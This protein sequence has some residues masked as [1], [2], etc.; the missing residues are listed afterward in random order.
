MSLHEATEV[1]LNGLCQRCHERLL[2]GGHSFVKKGEVHVFAEHGVGRLMPLRLGQNGEVHL[3]E[4]L[5][6]LENASGIS[7]Q[8]RPQRQTAPRAAAILCFSSADL[9]NRNPTLPPLRRMAHARHPQPSQSMRRN[10]STTSE[11]RCAPC[12]ANRGGIG[13]NKRMSSPADAFRQF[14]QTTPPNVPVEIAGLLEA[15]ASGPPPPINSRA[16]QAF[17]YELDLPVIELHCETCQRKQNFENDPDTKSFN[18]IANFF[19]YFTCKNCGKGQKVIALRAAQKSP[20]AGQAI[21]V[22]LV[23]IGEFPTFGPP[24]SRRVNQLLD[25]AHRELFRKGLRA[26]AQGLGIA[27]SAY[28]RRIVEEQ[29]SRVLAEL[30]KVAVQLGE[31]DLT[32]YDQAA[33][34]KRFTYAIDLVSDRLPP[35]LRL[36]DGSNPLKLLHKV[37]SLDVHTRSDEDCLADGTAV[38]NVL[39][40]LLERVAEVT[41]DHTA[42]K[43][44]IERIKAI[45]AGN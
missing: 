41:R 44:S 31:T 32:V 9:K 4:G 22:R 43:Q 13:D 19:V 10:R 21:D 18:G 45:N 33:G 24:V 5:G 37:L 2:D 39:S 3:P 34:E 27:A 11:V 6:C 17:T 1:G 38:K 15:R 30:R 35:A 16:R 20:P 26:E 7:T 8:L 42:L 40:D 23:K 29:W 14:L 12:G 36:P 25:D 28:F